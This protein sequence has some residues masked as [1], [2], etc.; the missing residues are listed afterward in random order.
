MMKMRI[1]KFYNKLPRSIRLGELW[2][3]IFGVLSGL[4]DG[5]YHSLMFIRDQCL[6]DDNHS[7]PLLELEAHQTPTHP[8]THTPNHNNQ[9][10]QRSS[11]PTVLDPVGIVPQKETIHDKE[12]QLK[13]LTPTQ[14]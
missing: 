1:L 3:Y 11:N 10:H 12:T 9:P 7:V 14:V 2:Q 8:H 6:L 5:Q 4:D 13:R